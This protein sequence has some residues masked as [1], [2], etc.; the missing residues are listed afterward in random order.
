[1]YARNRKLWR[2]ISRRPIKSTKN[3]VV[4][5]ATI[6]T[7]SVTVLPLANAVKTTLLDDTVTTRVEEQ[8]SIKNLFLSMRLYNRTGNLPGQEKVVLFL[9]RNPGAKY[10]APTL[11]ECNTLG[12]QPWRNTVFQ[13]QIAKPPGPDGLPMGLAPIRIPR[14]FHKMIIDDQW[15]L[16]IGNNSSGSIDLCGICLYKWFN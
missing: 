16:I 6:A 12:L 5:D 4:L 9:R 10:A 7:L 15:E 11:A 14:R 3:I 13:V 8:C 2:Q 1:M